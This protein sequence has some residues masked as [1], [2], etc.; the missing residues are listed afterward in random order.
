MAS[1][2]EQDTEHRARMRTQGMRP[3]EIWVPDEAHRT[4]RTKTSST[5]SVSRRKTIETER[6]DR[7]LAL[8]H[9]LAS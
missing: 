4:K 7:A 3:I 5:P 2:Q 8:F 1:S 9:G 6:V